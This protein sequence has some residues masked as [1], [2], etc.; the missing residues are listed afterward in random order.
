MNVPLLIVD[1]TDCD[2]GDDEDRGD[3]IDTFRSLLGPFDEEADANLDPFIAD[4]I[5]IDDGGWVGWSDMSA[6]DLS[7]TGSVKSKEQ[8]TLENVVLCR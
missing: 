7:T 5:K 2:V 1:W 4:L 3:W 6:A 8:E